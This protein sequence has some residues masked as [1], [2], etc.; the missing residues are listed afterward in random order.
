MYEMA[1]C[2]MEVYPMSDE[3]SSPLQNHLAGVVQRMERRAARGE[4]LSR[5]YS[6]ARL[7]LFCA[8]GALTWA[9]TALSG[10]GA[11]WL[12][13]GAALLLFAVVAGLHR[14]VD[15]WNEKFRVW[16]A[17]HAEQLARL[18]LDWAHIPEAAAPA[19]GNSP[20]ALDLD[21]SGPR[22]LHHLIDRA[23]SRQ[24]SARLA[25]W[26]SRG[27]PDCAQI[28]A[29][30]GIVRELKRMPRFCN[31]LLLAFRLLTRQPLDAEKLL[32][33][34]AIPLPEAAL[35]RTL[36]WASLLA[37]GNLALLALNVAGKLPPLW[38]LSTLLYAGLYFANQKLVGEFLAAVVRLDEELD[39]FQ[40]LLRFLETYPYGQARRLATLCAPF[41][42][43]AERPARLLRQV[44]WA[45]AAAGLR[46]NPALGVLLNL[47]TPWDF[48]AAWLAARQKARMARLLPAW[49]DAFHELEALV[50]LGMFAAQNPAYAFPQVAPLAPAAAAPEAGMVFTARQMGHPL[51]P[52]RVYN[53]FSVQALG[54]LNLIT[55]SNMAG[56]STFIRT[57][58]VNLCLAYAGGPVCA[59]ELC[60]APFRLYTCIRV[61]DSLND[62]FSYFY[63][64]V[65]RLKGLLESIQRPGDLPLLYLIDE[66]FRGTNN[67]ERLIGSRAY[68]KALLGAPAVG[69][70]ATHDLELATLAEA[71]PQARNFH[72]RDEVSQGRLSFDYLIRCGVSPTTNAL[73]IMALEGLPV[74]E[75]EA[76]ATQPDRSA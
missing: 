63:A 48:W 76:G 20:L 6:W 36:P 52:R 15:R 2:S 51:L 32:A 62:H 65:K 29:R 9:A 38:L 70:L 54:E 61:N 5:G 71:H 25:E 39:A 22:S 28:E 13:F 66:I 1:N 58:G 31:R 4:A 34:L 53:D 40:P 7:A 42:Q 35:R 33:W 16:G 12:V 26:L 69:F 18:R 17:L 8:G 57:V 30:Q 3:I 73:K 67:R 10:P 56:K 44:K 21:L 14:R 60:S 47:L 41:A 24:G 37:L 23:V 64:E 50:S 55:G 46:M 27:A 74:D 59:A 68:V 72:F 45:T 43:G 19:A 11:G 75:A 49:L